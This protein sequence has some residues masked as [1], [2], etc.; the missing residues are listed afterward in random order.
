MVEGFPSELVYPRGTLTQS[1]TIEEEGRPQFVAFWETDD[2]A[3]A[4]LAFY[5]AAFDAL[6]LRGER[7]RSSFGGIAT[8]VVGAPESGATVVFDEGSGQNGSNVVT[9]GYFPE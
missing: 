3:D 5:E 4:V 2:D 1:A 7:E 9:V 8:L 6:G